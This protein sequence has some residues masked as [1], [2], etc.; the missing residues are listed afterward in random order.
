LQGNRDENQ[1]VDPSAARADAQALIAAGWSSF[2]DLICCETV[3]PQL[4]AYI[5]VIELGFFWYG[6]FVR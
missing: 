6:D 3:L 4:P 5:S 1:T 2:L